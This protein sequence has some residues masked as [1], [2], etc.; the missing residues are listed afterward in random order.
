[1]ISFLSPLALLAEDDGATLPSSSA[2]RADWM[3]TKHICGPFL[4]LDQLWLSLRISATAGSRAVPYQPAL[5][6]F[7][8]S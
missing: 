1:M 6:F 8:L 3:G 2:T 4:M 5:S 7:L